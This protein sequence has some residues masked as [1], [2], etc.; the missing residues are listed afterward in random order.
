MRNESMV[1]A[2]LEWDRR[3]GRFGVERA[4]RTSCRHRGVT[5]ITCQMSH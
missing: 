5:G 4:A 1:M 3:A 2:R